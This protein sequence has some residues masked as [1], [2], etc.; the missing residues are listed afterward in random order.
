MF[1]A[2]AISGRRGEV[3]LLRGGEV[4]VY[5][6]EEAGCGCDDV[7]PMH[8]VWEVGW[9][10]ALILGRVLAA[11][12]RCRLSGKVVGKRPSYWDG[13]CYGAGQQLV[14]LVFI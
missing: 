6:C 3:V 2:V 4:E 12:T 10:E 7:D 1:L 11:E 5:G 9:E 14:F 13:F 8:F